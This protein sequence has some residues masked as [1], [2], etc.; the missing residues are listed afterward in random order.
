MAG[1]ALE[2]EAVEAEAVEAEAEAAEAEA[3]EAEAVEAEVEVDAG[4]SKVWIPGPRSTRQK[5][6]RL[7]C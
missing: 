7:D 5:R 3:A 4:C 1:L 2:G 6:E